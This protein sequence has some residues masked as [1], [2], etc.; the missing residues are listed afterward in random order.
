MGFPGPSSETSNITELG[1]TAISTGGGVV[2]AGTERVT[3]GAPTAANILDGFNTQS[4]TQGATTLITI[5][6]GRTWKGKIGASCFIACAAANTTNGTAACVFSVAGAGATPAAGSIFAV[7]AQ[8]APTAAGG[9][10]GTCG[11]NFGSTDVVVIAPA[12]N[13]VT[14]QTTITVS[15]AATQGIVDAFATGELI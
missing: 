6:A 2:D 7:R 1:G 11:S 9:T 4:A 15:A 13:S 12:G 3:P 5:P 10:T 8:A 14:I